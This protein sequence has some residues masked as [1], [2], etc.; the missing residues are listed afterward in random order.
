[1]PISRSK[2][3]PVHLAMLKE[4]IIEAASILTQAWGCSLSETAEKMHLVENEADQA[5]SKIFELLDRAVDPPAWI[6]DRSDLEG[7]IHGLDDLIDCMEEVISDINT[8]EI[9]LSSLNL[10]Y[11]NQPV[12]EQIQGFEVELCGNVFEDFAILISRAADITVRAISFLEKQQYEK[13]AS[14]NYVIHIS[15]IERAGDHLRM[16]AI[17]SL[18]STSPQSPE[19]VER[20]SDI[21]RIFE[22]FEKTVDSFKHTSVSIKTLMLKSA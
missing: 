6:E 5:A 21:R 16:Q 9:P 8:F 22:I 13:L 20:R 12:K 17:R 1:M 14:S 15:E 11:A 3:Y 19:E 4:K 2:E 7:F 18:R 10:S